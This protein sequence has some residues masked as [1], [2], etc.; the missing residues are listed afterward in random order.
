MVDFAGRPW[1]GVGVVV[2]ARLDAWFTVLVASVAIA[3]FESP[4][5]TP[6]FVLLFFF[7]YCYPISAGTRHSKRVTRNANGHLRISG[8]A[9][10][11]GRASQPSAGDDRGGV[12]ATGAEAARAED[13]EP[14][15]ERQEGPPSFACYRAARSVR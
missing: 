8:G 12:A 13:Q 9:G 4:P 15:P 11:R 6:V 10:D 3:Q 1:S 5:R 7:A 14:V 2:T